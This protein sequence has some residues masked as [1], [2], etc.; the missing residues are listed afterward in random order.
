MT[1]PLLRALEDEL[2]RLRQLR[3][4]VLEVLANSRLSPDDKVS[5]IERVFQ[6]ERDEE[7]ESEEVR[8]RERLS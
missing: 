1:D 4:A 6:A 2:G 7:D 8:D 5:A 3:E